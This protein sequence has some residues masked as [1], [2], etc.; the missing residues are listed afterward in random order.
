MGAFVG[1]MDASG[2]DADEMDALLRGVGAASR[3]AAYTV[4]RHALI[5]GA[6][7]E[8]ML[9]RVLGTV[10]I[11]ELRRGP[12]CA[13][14]DLRSGQ[15]VVSRFGPPA[16]SVGLSMRLPVLAPGQVRGRRE[17]VDGSLIDNLP[18][19]TL[20]ALARGP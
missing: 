9:G 1:A 2:V 3:A 13:S 18:L 8:A 5:R 15:F 7:V 10:A 16:E 4:L 11:E 17:L 20:A 19:S 6:R 14:A 12:F